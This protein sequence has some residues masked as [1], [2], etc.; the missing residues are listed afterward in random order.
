MTGGERS[1]Q[2]VHVIANEYDVCAVA[3]LGSTK[4]QRIHAREVWHVARLSTRLVHGLQEMA[5]A[6]RSNGGCRLEAQDFVAHLA[7]SFHTVDSQ[8]CTSGGLVPC[9]VNDGYVQARW[10][11]EADTCILGGVQEGGARC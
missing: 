10:A 7:Q 9:S 6:S 5:T 4:A 3:A 11:R 8:L 2:S 1:T